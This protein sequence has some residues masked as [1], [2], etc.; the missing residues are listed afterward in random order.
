MKKSKSDAITGITPTA[1]ASTV[2][3]ATGARQ[4]GQRPAISAVPNTIHTPID[5]GRVVSD[6]AYVF[7]NVH[8]GRTSDVTRALRGI[9]QIKTIDPCWGKPDIIVVVEVSDQ[10]AMTQL[11][12]S[13]IHEIDGVSQTETHL[14]YRLKTSNAA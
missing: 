1:G 6:R 7:I 11:V 14:V 2:K 13:R 8:P 5:G 9:K 3:E 12:L 4:V 10:D